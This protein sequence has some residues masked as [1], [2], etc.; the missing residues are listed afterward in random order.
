MA[1]LEVVVGG[2]IAENGADCIETDCCGS[3][4][5]GSIYIVS[6]KVLGTGY[7]TANGGALRESSSDVASGAGG[8]IAIYHNTMSQHLTVEVG[9]GAIGEEMMAYIQG[10]TGSYYTECL[11]SNCLNG[12]IKTGDCG[13]DCVTPWAGHDCSFCPLE[14]YNGGSINEESCSCS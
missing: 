12:G 2:I 9:G 1:T 4:S 7:I 5:G 14:C 6:D 13:C 11:S 10:K 3:A 8:R